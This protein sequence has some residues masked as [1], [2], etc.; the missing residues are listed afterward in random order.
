MPFM[1]CGRILAAWALGLASLPAGL[2]AQEKPVGEPHDAPPPVRRFFDRPIDYW[3]HGL[4]TQDEKK[5][6]SPGCGS[7]SQPDGASKPAPSDWGQLVKQ[8]DGTMAYHELPRPLVEVLEDPTPEKIRAYFEWKLARTQKILRAAEAMKEYK[9][10]LT[11]GSRPAGPVPAPAPGAP[12]PAE[13]APP[14]T[15]PSPAGAPG[16]VPFTVTYF[17]RT[18]CPHCDTQDAILGRWLKDKPE[19]KLVRVD[20]GEKPEL[21]QKFQV[22]GTPS[23]VIEASGREKPVFLEG[24]S[25]EAEL[26]QALLASSTPTVKKPSLDGGEKK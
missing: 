21:W 24:V 1:T 16:K 14:R 2:L 15:G 22:R 20:F 23:L 7:L 3:Q 25:Q 18:G 9:S 13:I 10:S 11:E 8:P 4:I 5:P 12:I 6:A 26:G 19:A 17:H